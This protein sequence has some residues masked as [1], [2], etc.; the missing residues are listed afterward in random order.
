MS[1]YLGSAGCVELRRTSL[2]EPFISEIR[3]SDVN[4]KTNRFSF[5]FPVGQFLTGD[6]IEIKAL[7]RKPLDFVASSGW[8]HTGATPSGTPTTFHDGKFFIHVDQVGGI[9]LYVDFD[10]AMSGEVLGRVDLLPPSRVIPISVAVD[11]IHE[12]IIAQITDFEI[13][14]E[15]EAV[16]VTELGDS[17]RQ[18]YSG[19]ISGSGRVTCFFE[20]ERRM[21]DN[22]SG[23]S[24]GR[25]EMPVYMNQLI[26]R[27]RIGSEFF[28]KLTL[29]GRGEKPGSRRDDFDDEVWYEFEAVV[30]SVAMAFVPG[31]P[32]RCNIN[33]IT[34][35]EI[36]LKTRAVSNYIIQ[37]QSFS[38][39]VMLEAYQS[40]YLEHEQEE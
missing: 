25:L 26:L 6:M 34:T 3:P 17:F 36:H 9:K 37:E 20:Y 39:R 4:E 23:A 8:D 16:D 1:V 38:D 21:C 5:D 33:F 19:L 28:A 27:S 29:A 32:V 11:N 18:Q 2:E 10:L 22:M 35:G 14:T 12:R 40:G 31:E 13:N 30:S 24:S 7:D 15:R